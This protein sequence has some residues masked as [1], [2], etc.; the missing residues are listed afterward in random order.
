VFEYLAAGRPILAVVPP[1]GEA[2]ELVRV[3]GAGVVV[4]PEDVDGIAA[5]LGELERRWRDDELEPLE[6]S[7]ELRQ[8]L[9]RRERAERL[10]A[11]LRRIA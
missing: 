3:T 6:L 10:A 2:A 9:S 4:A 8:R 11:L 7:P 5:A 1:E